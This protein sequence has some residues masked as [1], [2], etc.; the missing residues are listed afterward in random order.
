[1]DLGIAGLA[2]E[3]PFV[4]NFKQDLRFALN[5]FPMTTAHF[6]SRLQSGPMSSHSGISPWVS[7]GGGLGH[8][9][10]NSSLEF[11]GTNPGTTGTT[12]GVFQIGLGL[13]VH[14][15]SSLSVRGPGAGLLP[16]GAGVERG[17]RQEPPAQLFRGRRSGLA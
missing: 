3:V 13:D 9:S 15:L 7:A 8:F 10:E 14:L 1:M 17:Y 12:T 5:L 16:R 6:S 2:F 11:G 4:I